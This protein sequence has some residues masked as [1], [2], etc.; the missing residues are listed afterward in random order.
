MI[1]QRITLTNLL[2]ILG[3]ISVLSLFILIPYTIG[4]FTYFDVRLMGLFSLYDFYFFSAYP[5]VLINLAIIGFAGVGYFGVKR[6]RMLERGWKRTL[7][8]FLFGFVVLTPGVLLVAPIGVVLVAVIVAA[9]I[10][11]CTL[12]GVQGVSRLVV[13][14][15][16]FLGVESL[17]FVW[18][19][20]VAMSAFDRKSEVTV[21]SRD[22][23]RKGRAIFVGSNS[24]LTADPDGVLAV[25]RL[26]SGANVTFTKA[27]HKKLLGCIEWKPYVWMRDAL[28]I[29]CK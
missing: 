7:R 19:N 5:I 17:L 14:F 24:I 26:D 18:G 16:I 3:L 10:I 8:G 2:A 11:L 28:H 29:S 25:T 4:Y 15:G 12:L 20:M 22:I 21:V 1:E 9:V 6:G 23:V 27:N 13:Y